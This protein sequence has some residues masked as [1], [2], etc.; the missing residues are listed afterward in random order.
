[1]EILKEEI[2]KIFK[3]LYSNVDIKSI[4]KSEKINF[5]KTI[6]VDYKIED[7]TKDEIVKCLL[8]MTEIKFRQK[9]LSNYFVETIK[10]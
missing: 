1:M 10:R 4:S 3:K 7:F 9:D 2:S 8:Y 5:I 6:L